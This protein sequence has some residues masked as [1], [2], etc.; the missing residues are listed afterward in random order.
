MLINKT[1]CKHCQQ[2]GPAWI[3]KSRRAPESHVSGW[4]IVM[5]TSPFKEQVRCLFR[6][7]KD[8]CL[9][10]WQLQVMTPMLFTQPVASSGL[11]DSINEVSVVFS[12]LSALVYRLP[13]VSALLSRLFSV[14]WSEHFDTLLSCPGWF[15]ASCQVPKAE[16]AESGRLFSYLNWCWVLSWV[17]RMAVQ[18]EGASCH[19]TA[20]WM[21]PRKKLVLWHVVLHSRTTIWRKG[22]SNL[23]LGKVTEYF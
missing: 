4:L 19:G 8:P 18:R 17:C 3:N 5:L 7:Q 6:G 21:E 11:T 23:I 12:F 14:A 10:R 13:L 1:N 22:V 16:P 2:V 9:G 20:F 15:W